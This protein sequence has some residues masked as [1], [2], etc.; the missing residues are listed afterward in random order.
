M[1]DLKLNPE[2]LNIDS[3]GDKHPAY[4]HVFDIFQRYVEAPETDKRTKILDDLVEFYTEGDGQGSFISYVLLSLAEITPCDSPVHRQMALLICD[5][6][7]NEKRMAKSKTLGLPEDDMFLQQLR[8]DITDERRHPS[9]VSEDGFDPIQCANFDAFVANLLSLGLSESLAWHG[10]SAMECAFKED[11]SN[12][13]EVV[14]NACVIAA[15]QW[16]VISARQMLGLSIQGKHALSLAQWQEWRQGFRTAT[17]DSRLRETARRLADD[18]ADI[19]G[20]EEKATVNAADKAKR[21][22]P[23]RIFS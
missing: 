16:F 13:N 17:G 11:H 4:R 7:E 1:T 21:S 6:Q 14:R 9:E 18:A 3:I 12:H 23:C 8:G 22:D 10:R 20:L 15:A 19:M 5:F 2:V